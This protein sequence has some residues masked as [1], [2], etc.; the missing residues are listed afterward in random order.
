M[1]R[2]PASVNRSR[3]DAN[4]GFGLVRRSETRLGRRRRERE[5]KTARGDGD[6]RVG[7]KSNPEIGRA[8]V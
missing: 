8:H 2:P 7:S 5:E 3:I 4:L 1:W 6:G